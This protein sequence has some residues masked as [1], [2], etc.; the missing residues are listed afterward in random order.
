MRNFPSKS[1]NPKQS[2]D[3]EL[4]RLYNCSAT[5]L[6]ILYE[7]AAGGS[8]PAREKLHQVADTLIQAAGRYGNDPGTGKSESGRT[9]G[10]RG[11]GHKE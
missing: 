1:L 6:N 7:A 2:D 3:I 9:L 11:A 8:S 4:A 10:R 5:A